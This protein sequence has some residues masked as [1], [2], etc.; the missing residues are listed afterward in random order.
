MVGREK[1]TDFPFGLSFSEWLVIAEGVD[2]SIGEWLKALAHYARPEERRT[3][4]SLIDAGL[5][6]MVEGKSG[7][8]EL[9]QAAEEGDVVVAYRSVHFKVDSAPDGDSHWMAGRDF[10][11]HEKTGMGR[12]EQMRYRIVGVDGDSFVV[13][14]EGKLEASVRNQKVTIDGKWRLKAKKENFARID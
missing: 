7:E 10:Y 14:P 1:N 8:Y 5:L 2:A 3:L 11:P 13:S 9:R 12:P 4:D 6:R